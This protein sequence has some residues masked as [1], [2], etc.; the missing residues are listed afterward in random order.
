MLTMN[1]ILTKIQSK[2][3]IEPKNTLTVP[4]RPLAFTLYL[5]NSNGLL[6]V[7]AN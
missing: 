5:T 4:I 7:S 1:R 2:V 6:E 3:R